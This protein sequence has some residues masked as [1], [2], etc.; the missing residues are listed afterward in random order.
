MSEKKRTPWQIY[1]QNLGEV[2]PWDFLKS[3]TPYATEEVAEKRLSI[4]KS[5]PELIQIT[6]TC[7]KCGCFMA[8][9]VKLDEAA[10]PL[11]KW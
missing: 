6:S 10:C 8:A 5:C 1:K 4:C 2:R 3:D 9:K 11:E 7:K